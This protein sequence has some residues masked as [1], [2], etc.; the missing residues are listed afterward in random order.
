VTWCWFALVDEAPAGALNTAGARDLDGTGV[1]VL[2]AWPAGERPRPDAAR[3][4]ARILDP[5]GPRMAVSLVL[6]PPGVKILFD[7][8]TVVGAVKAALAGPAPDFRSTLSLD[9]SHFGGAVS[10]LA[11]PWPG[12]WSDD[13][14][15]RVFAA[16][17][18]W[19]D[20][21]MFGRVPPPAGPVHQRYGP[22]PWPVEGF[23]E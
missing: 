22:T 1:G 8:P 19:V 15:A 14:F 18:L 23:P 9:P 12:W 11:Q 13:P 2:A 20:A 16:R 4:D 7:D 10:G 6:P 5:D 17:Q 3:A 21:G